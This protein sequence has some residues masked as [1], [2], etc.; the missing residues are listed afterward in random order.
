MT[1]PIEDLIASEAVRQGLKM[2]ADAM[3][4]AAMD[5]AGSAMTK[6]KLI[7]MPGKG[8][9]SPRDYVNS[10]RDLMPTAFTTVV[11]DKT[12]APDERRTG[13]TLTA[14]MRRQIGTGRKQI[15]L[16]DDFDQVR[17]RY[18]ASTLTV[19]MMDELAASRRNGK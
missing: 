5:L 9:I 4:T 2:N 19:K 1:D 18:A 13:E 8:S 14:Y 12:T 10:L 11:T 17:S 16:P 15:P 7:H 6:D 3:R